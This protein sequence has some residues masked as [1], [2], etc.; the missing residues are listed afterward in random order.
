MPSALTMCPRKFTLCKHRRH[1]LGLSFSLASFN[2]LNTERKLVRCAG[3]D[4]PG[5][6]MS[7]IYTK[8][9]DHC[10]PASTASISLWKVAGALH[11]PKGI[12]LNSNRPSCVQKAVLS[13]SSGLTSTCQ[14][15]LNRSKVLNHLDPARVS[16]V[17][18]TRGRGYASFRVTELTFR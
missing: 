14:Y 11:S 17:S 12:T 1:F 13:L 4:F 3:N 2:L 5:I 8:H 6:I 10:R 9:E 15:P 7:S 16:R 18:S